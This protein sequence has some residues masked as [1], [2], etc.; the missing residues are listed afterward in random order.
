MASRFKIVTIFG[1]RPEIIKLY[2]VIRHLE[3]RSESVSL[4]LGTGQQREMQA[5]MTNALDIHVDHD[6]GVM[7][8]DQPLA[9][10]TSRLITSLTRILSR[11][12]PDMILVQGDTT[13][14]FVAA[15]TAFYLKMPVGHVESGLRTG[16][17]YLPFPEEINRKLITSLADIHFA[18]TPGARLNLVRENVPESKIFITG[19]TVVDAMS[20]ISDGINGGRLKASPELEEIRGKT[21]D[22]KIVLVTGHRRESFGKGLKNICQALNGIVSKTPSA[23]VVYPVHPNPNVSLPVH[24]IIGNIPNIHLVKPLDYLSFVFLLNEAFMVLTDSGGIQEEAAALGKPTLIMREITERPEAVESGVAKLVGT[25][26]E[27]IR[28][29]AL[30]LLRDRHFYDAMAAPSKV[31]G[32]GKAAEYIV[33]LCIS[34]LKCDGRFIEKQYNPDNL[35]KVERLPTPPK[36]G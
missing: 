8:E 25:K 20:I 6:L 9:D 30:K 35:Q 1:T 34:F 11:I 10:L 7:E 3:S 19:N 12:R 2:P 26:T 33:D 22:K 13:T 23:A 5:Q 21:R 18:P 15:L 24:R 28:D 31:F 17:K 16:K 29:N 32:D 14:A 4:T 27:S 36:T